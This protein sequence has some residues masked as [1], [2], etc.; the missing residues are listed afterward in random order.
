[1]MNIDCVDESEDI[2]EGDS[3]EEDEKEVFDDAID[4]AHLTSSSIKQYW[5]KE[6]AN[7]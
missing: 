2:S 7:I 4:T 5:E 1:M 6:L 3:P